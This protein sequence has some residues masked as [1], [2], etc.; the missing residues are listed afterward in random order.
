MNA[1]HAAYLTATP[2][3]GMPALAKDAL[4]GIRLRTGAVLR[5][6]ILTAPTV[7]PTIPYA[8][9]VSKAMVFRVI[10]ASFVPTLTV[11]LAPK[12]LVIVQHAHNFMEF[13]EILVFLV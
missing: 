3:P 7:R 1:P 5:V 6:P 13:R 8:R 9:S 12:M 4:E 2:V 11:F 10:P